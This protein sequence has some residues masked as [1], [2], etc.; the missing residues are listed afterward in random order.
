MRRR[1]LR[2][3]PGYADVSHQALL[4]CLDAR[5]ECTPRAEGGIPLDRVG[6]VM[7]LNEIDPIHAQ[8]LERK[9]DLA[10]RRV[11]RATS[12]LGGEEKAIAVRFQPG[13][14]PQL[15]VAVPRGP[16]DVMPPVT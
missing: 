2:A 16:I 4:T 8:A 11:I 1:D 10:L 15:S 13:R 3:V 6:E 14:K 9:M 5:V 7:E 12:R